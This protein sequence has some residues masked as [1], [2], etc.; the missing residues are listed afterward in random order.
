M[1]NSTTLTTVRQDV[2]AL[3]S[4]VVD[5]ILELVAEQIQSV[6]NEG[7]SIDVSHAARVECCILLLDTNAAIQRL[8]LIGGFGDSAYLFNRIKQWCTDFG[9][10]VVCPKDP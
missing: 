3:F 9:I 5:H 8:V 1:P 2:E 4:P 10:R 6:E 7:Q